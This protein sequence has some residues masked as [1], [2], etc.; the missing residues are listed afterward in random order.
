MVPRQNPERMR[1]LLA[2][3]ARYGWSWGELSRRSGLPIWKLYW[4]RRRLAG[5]KPLRRSERTFVAVQ[6]VG[7]APADGL[8][9]EVITP[10]GF[11]VRV[12]TD[13]QGEHLRRVLEALE[14][15]C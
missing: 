8:P 1:A 7:S 4:W 5:H 14:G 10:S 15:A 9:L 3:R 6:V 13:F 12:P 11:R 2:R